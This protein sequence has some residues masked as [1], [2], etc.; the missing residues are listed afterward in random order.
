MIKRY[1]SFKPIISI[2]V[3]VNACI[4]LILLW[5]FGKSLGFVL[6][7]TG[8]AIIITGMHDWL[9]FDNRWFS[10]SGITIATLLIL[11]SMLWTFFVP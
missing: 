8:M 11:I 5:T 9:G 2:I 1:S 7:S 3:V 10:F 4:I 6:P